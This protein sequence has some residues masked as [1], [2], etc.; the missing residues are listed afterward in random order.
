MFD[1]RCV[2][3]THF[4]F[5][6]RLSLYLGASHFS[7]L[8]LALLCPIPQT[9]TAYPHSSNTFFPLRNRRELESVLHDLHS[10]LQNHRHPKYLPG[11]V[12]DVLQALLESDEQEEEGEMGWEGETLLRTQ[13]GDL[14]NLPLL[15]FPG[16]NFLESTN[17]QEGGEGEEGWKRTDA[18]TSI[19][20]GLQAVS[21]EKGG[22]GFRFGRKR[23]TEKERRDG[24]VGRQRTRES[25]K[26][27]FK[28]NTRRD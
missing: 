12:E 27:R 24:G 5:Q 22:F 6:M 17:Y 28:W 26:R 19:A 25:N 11:W 9:V 13:R 20:G 16:E 23:W 10:T 3:K 8:I 15:P 7:L 4:C 18:L 21:R 2:N 1:F 14:V